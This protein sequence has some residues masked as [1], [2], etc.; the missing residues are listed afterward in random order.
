MR[1]FILIVAASSALAQTVVQP[2]YDAR[3]YAFTRTSGLGASGDLTSAGAKTITLSSCPKGLSGTDTAHYVY[4]S[5]GTGTAEAVL[6]TGGTCT[7]G[8]PS[9]TITATTANSHSGA[10]AIT[11][12][13]AGLKEADNVA[14]AVGA[15]VFLPNGTYSTYA[16]YYATTSVI[17]ESRDGSIV[18]AR[19]DFHIVVFDVGSIG[20]YFKEVA[21]LTLRHNLSN[22]SCGIRIIG[23]NYFARSSFHDIH[24]SGNHTAIYSVTT[25]PLQHNSF[26]ANL[27]D[28][29]I[30]TP[31]RGFEFGH[32]G[33][34]TQILDNNF[35][36][37]A[38]VGDGSARSISFDSTAF[39]D[40]IISGNN[41]EGG[42]YGYYFI[43][44]VG[45]TYA[46]RMVV[47]GNKIDNATIP[48]QLAG[49]GVSGNYV[50][51]NSYVGGVAVPVV[52]TSGA[53]GRNVIDAQ[54]GY[55]VKYT[56]IPATGTAQVGIN[57]GGASVARIAVDDQ[58][59]TESLG[60]YIGASFRGTAQPS[61]VGIGQD[62]SHNVQLLWNY[63]ATAGSATASLLTF[64]YNNPLTIGGSALNLIGGGFTRATIPADGGVQYLTGT[65][66]TCDAAHRGTTF[67]VAGGAGVAD[68]LELCR[69]DG[70]DAYAWVALF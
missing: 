2:N 4:I 26:R 10:W 39:G 63:N 65:R 30:I 19:G 43:C 44:Q 58:Y 69:K 29:N 49:T 27:I 48:I 57:N 47:S 33:T 7:S 36:I 54:Y 40:L 70:A 38:A 11:S 12:A 62:G 1:Y 21:N 52:E 32:P 25:V 60:P 14:S 37:R 59:F 46:S 8:A 18:L 66:P 50:V 9:G 17:G 31:L 24:F 45:C 22:T 53:E 20:M 3:T 51:G 34:G 28:D 67:Y 56:D 42:D 41:T 5:G 35:Q 61:G 15:A 23:T 13:T 64:G 6:I 55:G 16:P 68:T